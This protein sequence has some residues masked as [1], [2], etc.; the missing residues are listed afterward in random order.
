MTWSV[1]SM[2][3]HA[4]D[5]KWSGYSEEAY[6]LP[7]TESAHADVLKSSIIT[8]AEQAIFIPSGFWRLRD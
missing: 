3:D 8:R 4:R 2:Q 7:D 6:H 5:D 1:G